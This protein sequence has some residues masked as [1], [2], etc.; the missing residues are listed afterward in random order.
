MS[1]EFDSFFD[2]SNNE[3]WFNV[4]LYT[5]GSRQ[6]MVQGISSKGYGTAMGRVAHAL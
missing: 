3:T 1:S 5:N 2:F 6:K 4:K